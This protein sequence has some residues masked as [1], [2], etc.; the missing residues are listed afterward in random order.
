MCGV[1]LGGQ[2]G[3][4]ILRRDAF[5]LLHAVNDEAAQAEEVF[6]EKK[7][8]R[9]IKDQRLTFHPQIR[10]AGLNEAEVVSVTKRVER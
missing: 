4:D 9:L 2:L 10:S 8:C 3:A 1:D 7:D 5:R 6:P